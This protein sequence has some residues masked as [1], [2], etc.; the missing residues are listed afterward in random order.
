MDE[1]HFANSSKP[2][3]HFMVDPIGAPQAT[4]FVTKN[5]GNA[6][7]GGPI[8]VHQEARFVVKISPGDHRNAFANHAATKASVAP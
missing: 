1:M 2:Q 7:Y 6:F 5:N 4:R 3:L 8:G